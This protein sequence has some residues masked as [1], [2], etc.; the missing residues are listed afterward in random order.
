MRMVV[1]EPESGDDM[2]VV[3]PLK[4]IDFE[5][6]EEQLSKLQDAVTPLSDTDD[7]GINLYIRIP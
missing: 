2:V 4:S 7:F 5:L 1:G 3:P 6:T